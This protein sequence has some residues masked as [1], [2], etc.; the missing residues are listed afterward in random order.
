V[1]AGLQ[2]LATVGATFRTAEW[3][4]AESVESVAVLRK[5]TALVN[6]AEV[7]YGLS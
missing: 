5:H 3:H 4:S 1:W 7:P 6:W 2:S